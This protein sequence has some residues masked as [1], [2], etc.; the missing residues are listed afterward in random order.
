MARRAE[1]TTEEAKAQP[2]CHHHWIIES[3]HGPTSKGVCKYCGAEKDFI[4]YS[5]DLWRGDDISTLFELPGLPDTEPDGK[6]G[7]R[8]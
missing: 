5:P 2:E 1:N 7:Q 3:P 8:R 4:N 6:G